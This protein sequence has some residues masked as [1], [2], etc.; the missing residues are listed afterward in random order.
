MLMARALTIVAVLALTAGCGGSKSPSS[1]DPDPT[2]TPVTFSLS[3]TVMDARNNQGIGG[4]IVQV[5]DG[6]NAG[7]RTTTSG[8]GQYTLPGLQRFAFTVSASAPYYSPSSAGVD[9]TQNRT[10]DYHLQY[11]PPWSHG[12][13]GDNVFDM[14]RT[15][16]RVKITGDYTRNSSNFVVY[17]A[18]DL[19]VNE[20]LGTGWHVTHFEGTYLTGGGT[21]EVKQ[22]S[23]VNWTFTEV[24]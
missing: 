16:S 10:Q 3:G 23:G 5:Q 8:S 14:P 9:L 19:V 17:I 24:R 13:T 12:G 18:G 1:P 6:P 11:I 21:V 2:P 22:S 7:F 4:A 15:V 20:L